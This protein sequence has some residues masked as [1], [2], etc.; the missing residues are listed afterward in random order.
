MAGKRRRVLFLVGIGLCYQLHA[1]SPVFTAEQ[2]QR[3]RIAYVQGCEQ[4]H[5][6]DMYGGRSAPALRGPRFMSRWA[7]R[8]V[9]SLFSKIQSTMPPGKAGTLP[10][11]VCA[12]I[13]A[14]IL[15]TSNFPAGLAPLPVAPAE[16]DAV[17]IP[18]QRALGLSPEIPLPPAP[19][20]LHLTENITAV[21]DAILAS[22]PTGDWL[23]WR[24][25][26]DSAGFSP[27]NEINRKNVQQLQVA[28]SLALPG[29]VNQTT[30]LVKDGV[31]F[32]SSFGDHVQA[33]DAAT[34][35]EYW[36]YSR[37]I[38]RGFSAMSHRNMALYADKLYLAASDSSM[39]ALSTRTGK[40][41][42]DQ[43]IGDELTFATGGPL[44]VDGVVMMGLSGETPGGQFIVGLDAETGKPL[45]RFNTIAQPGTAAGDSW[46]GLPLKKRTGGGVWTAG[47]YDTSSKLVFFGVAPTYDTG[48]LRDPVALPGTTNDALYT[49]STVALELHTGR[50]VWHFQH[51]P[52]D[53]WDLDWAFER[54]IVNLRVDGK[55]RRILVTASKGAYFDALDAKT[56][57]YLFSIDLGLQNVIT[58]A[59]PV[60][61]RKVVDRALIP[62]RG[63]TVTVCPHVAGAKSWTPASLNPENRV[64]YVTLVESCMDLVSVTTGGY[65]STGVWPN[66]RPRPNSDGKYGRLQAI[67]LQSRQTLW[68]MRQ[69]APL[70]TGALATSG[71]LVFAGALDRRL[72]AYDA[73]SGK[74]LWTLRL[75]D[76]PSAAPISYLAKG[77]QHVAVVVG[78][79]HTAGYA[80]TY[81]QFLPEERMPIAPSS[82][83]WVF[84][85]PH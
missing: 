45:W 48:P 30:P 7:G 66:L 78:I 28:W 10:D 46:N 84:K 33:L 54:Q 79:S 25:T 19:P 82:A 2:A 51:L 77:Q 75:S 42:W 53:Q 38:A 27:L 49:N 16:L 9:G 60:T 4:C 72:A 17:R 74:S 3:G 22:P 71:G 55:D 63:K 83:I 57:E 41:I 8:S 26:Q 59:D 31:M 76:V 11:Q 12:E 43:R 85:L 20:R 15:G 64:L 56:G 73:D 21:T 58:D 35:D 23:S 62:G 29:G 65:L 52:N 18:D 5:G 13:T 81:L 39:V 32:V 61:G 34:G 80:G 50:L 24:R 44:V 69:R 70:T 1:Q 37:Q 47:S 14:Y 68:S 6:A 67:D 36:R 40:V